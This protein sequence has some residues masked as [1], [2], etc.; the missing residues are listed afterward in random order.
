MKLKNV[1]KLVLIALVLMLRVDVDAQSGLPQDFANNVNAE[2]DKMTQ[3]DLS[4]LVMTKSQ[5]LNFRTKDYQAREDH[6]QN[7]NQQSSSGHNMCDGGEFNENDSPNPNFW[8]F[9]WGGS[10]WGCQGPANSGINRINTGNFDA[11]GTHESLVHHE[12]HSPG[13]DPIVGALINRVPGNPTGNNSALRLGQAGRG[14]GYESMTKS[15]VEITAENATL[16]FSYALV[17]NDPQGHQNAKPYFAVNIRDANTGADYSNLVNLGNSSNQIASDNPLLISTD[18]IKFGDTVVYKDWNCVTVDLSSLIGETIHIEFYNRD[19]WAGAH[20]G[21]TYLDNICIGCTTGPEGEVDLDLERS[22]DCGVGQICFDYT[23]PSLP[24]GQTGTMQIDLEI[25]QNATLLH[26]YSSP[27]L[28]SG[29][30]YCFN[31]DPALIPNLDASLLGFDYRAVGHPVINGFPLSPKYSGSLPFGHFPGS[32]NDYLIDCGGCWLDEIKP[33]L[34]PD[35]FH[36]NPTKPNWS[37]NNYIHIPNSTLITSNQLWQGKYYIPDGVIITVSNAILDLTNVDLIFGECAGIQFIGDATV[38]ANNSVFRSCDENKTWLGFMFRGTA[39]GIINESTFKSAQTALNF[40]EVQEV[41]VRIVNNLFQNCRVGIYS[42]RSTFYDGITGNTF[43][44]DKNAIKY[45]TDC[46]SLID[47]YVNDYQNDHWGILANQSGFYGN[48]SQNDF[49]N[50][51]EIKGD[52]DD[53]SKLFYGITISE[54]SPANISDNNFT[55]MYRSIDIHRSQDIFIDNNEIEVNSYNY[56]SNLRSEHQIRLSGSTGCTVTGNNLQYAFTQERTDI[57]WSTHSAIYMEEGRSISVRNNSI[58][59]FESGIQVEKCVDILVKENNFS[60]IGRTGIFVRDGNTIDVICNTINMEDDYSKE[61]TTQSVGIYCITESDVNEDLRFSGNCIFEASTAILM[62]GLRDKCYPLPWISNNFMY[63]YTDVGIDVV[64][65]QGTIGTPGTAY[66]GGRNTF[67]SNNTTTGSVDL[68]ANCTVS[69]D[70]NYGII[71]TSGTVTVG[72]GE[73]YSTASC[74]AQLPSSSELLE[75]VYNETCDPA[76]YKNSNPIGNTPNGGT[77]L[78]DNIDDVLG[79]TGSEKYAIQWFNLVK[80]DK[81]VSTSLRDKW[82]AATNTDGQYILYAYHFVN[83][84]YADAQIALDACI[85]SADRKALENVRLSL[86]VNEISLAKDAASIAIL[87][88]IREDRTAYYEAQQM[89]Q[90]AIAG[91]DYPFKSIPIVKTVKSTKVNLLDRNKLVAYPNPVNSVLN[92]NYHFKSEGNTVCK[93][94]DLTGKVMLEK[95]ITN[96]SETI[97]MDVEA[98]SAGTYF[99]QIVDSEGEQLTAKFIK[100]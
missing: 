100:M 99:I 3:S 76:F 28:A 94:M 74:G 41:K 62:E 96:R 39:N 51:Q 90:L 44:V 42:N 34:D 59:G 31:I 2:Y 33:H 20:F 22:D 93:V 9:I 65:L 17:M 67:A 63:N 36:T 49:V 88:D 57:D 5:Y 83:S 16:T 30:N 4:E 72:N 66:D 12:T 75:T 56:E 8:D 80:D 60:D 35:I 82:L 77:K 98:L 53:T 78:N 58:Q 61:N 21:Y 69:A 13:N 85:Q 71:T 95:S 91:N 87:R 97:S 86:A 18:I 37:L 11:C 29:S 52:D 92:I 27:V 64:D 38:R 45:R 81:S 25:Y 55:D 24:S 84:N 89:L 70:G 40:A 46:S 10:S 73:F 19:C 15:N 6:W 47:V 43:N 26:T 50:A 23:L 1:L 68:R 14:F 32:N 7:L 48:I 54:G 79:T